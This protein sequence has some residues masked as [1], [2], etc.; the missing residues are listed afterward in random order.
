MGKLPDIERHLGNI[1]RYS[2][3]QKVKAIYFENVH[4][5]KLAEFKKILDVFKGTPDLIRSLYKKRQSF[6][7]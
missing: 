2:V 5:N 1:F 7:S 6:K 4:L 3:K